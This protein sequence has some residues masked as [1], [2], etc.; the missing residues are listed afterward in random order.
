[1]C[2]V[3][4]AT[5]AAC[6]IPRS[7]WPQTWLNPDWDPYAVLMNV[8]AYREWRRLYLARKGVA[9]QRAEIFRPM[10]SDADGCG[11]HRT[12]Q[13]RRGSPSKRAAD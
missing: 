4:E 8:P 5:L 6:Q 9:E 2:K 11:G 13:P 1:M 7:Q 10:R 3:H 12:S